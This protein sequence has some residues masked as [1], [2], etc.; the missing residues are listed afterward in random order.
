MGKG[1]KYRFHC[2][3]GDWSVYPLKITYLASVATLT[4]DWAVT[5]L[6]QI[7][8]QKT[9]LCSTE[10][11][12]LNTVVIVFLNAGSLVQVSQIVPKDEQSLSRY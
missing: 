5:P 9:V 10:Y 3:H 12:V 1:L 8:K 4:A 7:R 6:L 11:A 2:H